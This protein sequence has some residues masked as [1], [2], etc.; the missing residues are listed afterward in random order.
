MSR[1]AKE[2]TQRG[3]S[4]LVPGL[5]T[6]SV[7]VMLVSSPHGRAMAEEG[8]QT[9][10]D[11]VVSASRI[12]VLSK[13]VGSAV[14]VITSEELERRQ[15]R[16]VS[17]VL[18]D[19]PGVAVSRSGGA[20]T[21]TQVRM[22]GA[23]ANQT[24]VLIDGVEVNNPA[25]GSEF[26]FATLL[27]S[28]VERIEVLRGPQSALYGSDAIGGVINIITKS[29][30][31]NGASFQASGEYGSFGTSQLSGSAKVGFADVVS[32]ALSVARFDTDGISAADKD[33]GNHENDGHENVTVNAKVNVKP[34]DFLEFDFSGRRVDSRV[35]FDGFVG[36]VG[37][38]DADNRTESEQTY[39]KAEVKLSLF[40][41]IWEHLGRVT[42]TRE[43]DENFGNDIET[44]ESDGQKTKYA[45]Q[46]S[47]FFETPAFGDFFETS[48]VT[49]AAH[50]LTFAVEQENDSIVSTSAFTNVDRE[51]ETTSY[52]GEYRLDLFE[53]LFLS[54]SV[55]HDDNDKLFDDTTTYRATGA[56]LHEPTDTRLHA[57]YG[58]GVKNPTAF[59]LFGFAANFVGNPALQPEEN[60]GWDVGIEQTFFGGDAMLDVTYFENRIENLILGAGNTAINLNGTTEI[61][62]VE[63][64]ARAEVLPDVT[65]VGSYTF[66]RAQDP[67]GNDLVRRA[68]HIASGNVNY[69]FEVFDRPGNVN[70]GV[71]Y[72]GPQKDFA[73]DAFFN[74]SVVTLDGF[75]LVNAAVDYEVFP[76]LAVFARGENLLDENYQEVLSFGTPGISF[77]AGVRA[78]LGP[79]QFDD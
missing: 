46:T 47:L 31:G 77:F 8:V 61:E 74:R 33:N 25:G 58:T 10:P 49:E 30:P 16:L 71:D 4:R 15:V 23:E 73:F 76:G 19:V 66:T 2:L 13:S 38:I 28:D 48:G 17:D 75:T 64:T 55:R 50:A 67:Q 7:I 32:A 1:N 68:K 69:A 72:N 41:G 21:F 54:G 59:E 43:F 63:V 3:P 36:G 52:V 56:Y 20:G 11:T 60:R 37:A 78:K 5:I 40:D 45:Y 62:G 57:S 65:V 12:P 42:Y 26:D 39:G 44:S 18:R 6:V 24:L 53:R 27:A 14:T 9:L 29:A 79:Y 22:R 70:I 51:L 35:E 34:T